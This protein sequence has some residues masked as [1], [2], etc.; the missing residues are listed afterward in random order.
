MNP[1]NILLVS[2]FLAISVFYIN[3]VCIQALESRIFSS[4]LQLKQ[5]TSKTKTI[6]ASKSSSAPLLYSKRRVRRKV[7]PNRKQSKYSFESVEYSNKSYNVRPNYISS[8]HRV[9]PEDS[10]ITYAT[11]GDFRYLDNLV[12]LVKRWRAPISIALFAPGSDMTSTLER[13]LYLRQCETPLIKEWVSFHLVTL[14][15]EP[16]PSPPKERH[17]SKKSM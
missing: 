7:R 5:I 1:R 2:F 3:Y 14:F 4:D 9:R 15:G 10:L 6:E 11:H 8:I 17:R 12:A 13:I 16:V